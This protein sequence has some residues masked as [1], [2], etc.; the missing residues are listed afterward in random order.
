MDSSP[1]D[2][3]YDIVHLF[4]TGE[5]RFDISNINY[6]KNHLYLCNSIGPTEINEGLEFITPCVNVATYL[7]DFYT[8]WSIKDEIVRCKYLNYSINDVLRNNRNHNYNEGNFIK[9]YTILVKKFSKCDNS[10]KVIEESVFK[11]VKELTNIYYEFNK[12]I[13]AISTYPNTECKDVSHT[14][15]LYLNILNRCKGETDK[16][17]IAVN[18]SKKNY[19]SKISQIKCDNV[20][21]KLKP[22]LTLDDINNVKFEEEEE[23]EAGGAEGAEAAG[24]RQDK[25]TEGVVR[26]EGMAMTSPNQ[27]DSSEMGQSKVYTPW[28]LVTSSSTKKK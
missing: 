22:F 9:A 20:E 17:C 3:Y 23:E 15:E 16:F 14:V 26:V 27:V 11:K 28:N 21:Y 6:N 7:E 10:V 1:D 5:D 12:Y 4:P 8:K 24:G 19:L 2:D 18:N 13:K 25:A